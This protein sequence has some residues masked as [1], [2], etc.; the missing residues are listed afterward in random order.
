M[1]KHCFTTRR[2]PDDP[3]WKIFKFSFKK[4]IIDPALVKNEMVPLSV[5]MEVPAEVLEPV[6]IEFEL[7][8]PV[9][10]F[11]RARFGTLDELAIIDEEKSEYISHEQHN[12][13][14]GRESPTEELRTVEKS[15]EELHVDEKEKTEQRKFY[16]ERSMEELQVEDGEIDEG[17]STEQL[18]KEKKDLGLERGKSCIGSS[19]EL[20]KSLRQLY[21]SRNVPVPR[22]LPSLVE[23]ME[24]S[25]RVKI[26]DKS[27][28]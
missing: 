22:P 15:T 25:K 3:L 28:N 4:P 2:I 23:L 24:A 21:R 18:Q 13:E 12:L 7:T 9:T 10:L 26:G 8:Q 5:P 16:G 17:E 1:K 19:K 20:N 11:G 6:E 27:S 14:S